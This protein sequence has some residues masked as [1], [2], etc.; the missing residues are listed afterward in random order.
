MD[1]LNPFTSLLAVH[2]TAVTELRVS[3]VLALG[4]EVLRMDTCMKANMD[5]V[6]T[7][8]LQEAVL[9][10]LKRVLVQMKE[11]ILVQRDGDE[12]LDI[13]FRYNG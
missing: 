8:A 4:A 13:T 5:D 2:G 7:G 11:E 12:L 10:M 6:E 3:D 1:N 9:R